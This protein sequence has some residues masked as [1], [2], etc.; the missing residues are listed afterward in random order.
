MAQLFIG[1]SCLGDAII[2]TGLLGRMLDDMPDDPITIACGPVAAL[3][4]RMTP[5]LERLHVM[6]K[7]GIAGHWTE[8]WREVAGRR[9]RRVVDMRRSAMPWLLR[10]DA[11]R[12]APRPHPGEHRVAV[13]ARTLGL[14][15][16][17]PRLWIDDAMRAEAARLAPP[18]R[19]VLALGIG[20]NWICKTWPADRYASLARRLVG[21][22]GMM[23]GAA[24]ALV[25][26]N[27]EREA[28]RPVAASLP[29][30]QVIDAFGLG[31]PTIAALLERSALFVGND[32]GM[33]HLAA[34]SGARTV[35][36]FGPTDDAAYAPWGEHGLVVRTPEPLPA[37]LARLRTEGDRS[38]L[39]ESLP[40]DT[41]LAAIARNWPSL[42]PAR[43]ALAGPAIAR[44]AAAE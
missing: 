5:R 27:D 23:E 28:A 34:A 6:R 31:I 35:G 33:M 24:V 38:T 14:P 37:L 19:P 13:A 7:R 10:A 29:A 39:M 12:I 1:P 8:L 32:S 21:P 20:A 2:A 41:V 43:P 26:S 36:L 3:V 40:V 16:L 9:W 30:S 18:G 11:R 4:L 42:E 22:G 17:P 25:G 15:P 44:N